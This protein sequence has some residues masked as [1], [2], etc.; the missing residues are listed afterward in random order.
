MHLETRTWLVSALEHSERPKHHEPSPNSGGSRE[1]QLLGEHPE[2]QLAELSALSALPTIMYISVSAAIA[3][4][5]GRR[6]VAGI[7]HISISHILLETGK[8]MYFN[9][10]PGYTG[11]YA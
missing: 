7:S 6:S 2:R 9:R 10:A 4:T 8:S 5:I 11:A 1:G 3:G